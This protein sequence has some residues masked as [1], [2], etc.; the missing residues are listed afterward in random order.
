M[1]VV[2]ALD[3]LE[4]SADVIPHVTGLSVSRTTSTFSMGMKGLEKELRSKQFP[5]KII[6]ITSS[7]HSRRDL[8]CTHQGRDGLCF[9][10]IHSPAAC[11]PGTTYVL[12]VIYLNRRLA[13]PKPHQTDKQSR[14]NYC[15]SEKLFGI[16]SSVVQKQTLFPLDLKIIVSLPAQVFMICLIGVEWKLKCG[17]N[18]PLHKRV[19]AKP[20]Q[21]TDYDTKL[22]NS[23]N[24]MQWYKK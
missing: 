12:E 5:R 9:F 20:A 11:S 1:S 16:D 3:H 15:T 22:S 7:L 14:G 4:N 21:G 13:K 6:L 18:I 17:K 8:P 19:S 2:Q 23:E 10:L 24:G